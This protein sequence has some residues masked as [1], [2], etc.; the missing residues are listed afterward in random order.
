MSTISLLKISFCI[1]YQLIFAFHLFLECFWSRRTGQRELCDDRKRQNIIQC[2]GPK[3]VSWLA[4]IFIR[5]CFA[6]S[7]HPKFRVEQNKCWR[8][9]PTFQ[10]PEEILRQTTCPIYQSHRGLSEFFT[11]KTSLSIMPTSQAQDQ[12]IPTTFK[13]Y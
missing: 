6:L 4:K 5:W 13:P 10:F 7:Q 8:R 1:V 2:D 3:T 11:D 12:C 9:W